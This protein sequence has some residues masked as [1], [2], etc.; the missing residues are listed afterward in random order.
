MTHIP[1]GY[2]ITAAQAV[3]DEVAAENVRRLFNEYLVTGSIRAATIRVGIEKTHSVIGRL[4]K[5][6][7]YLG[8]NY[9]PQIVD[10]ELFKRV[11]EL[12]NINAR[13]QNRIREYKAEK[14]KPISMFKPGAAK[15]LYEDPYSQAEYAYSLIEEVGNE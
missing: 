5:N 10:E 2:K 14:V 8:D 11:Q 15:V 13:N 1:Y 12:R 7:V 6:R 3:I 4:L 9:Y